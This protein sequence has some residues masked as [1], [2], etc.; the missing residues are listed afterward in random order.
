[1]FA[2]STRSACL[3]AMAVA[4]LHLAAAPA[5]GQYN[6]GGP[7]GPPG[8]PGGYGYGGYYPPGYGWGPGGYLAGGAAILDAT[9]NLGTS[10]EQAR[11]LRE[12]ANQAKLDTKKKAVDVMA[13][14]RTN[15]YWYS[16]E[17]IDINAKVIQAALNNPPTIE[18]TS[19]RALNTLL[20]YLDQMMSAGVPG[21]SVPVDPEVVRSLTVTSGADNGNVGLLKDVDNLEWPTSLVGQTQ[22]DLDTMLKEATYA[23]AMKGKV[24]PAA[25][26]KLNRTTDMLEQEVKTKFHKSEI[27]GGEYLEG[28]RYI[29][30]VRDAINAL[31][32]PTAGKFLSGAF[33]PR[34]DTVDQVVYSMASKGLTFARAQ[35]GQE[36]AYIALHRSFVNFAAAAGIP[37]T[38]F[39]VMVKGSQTPVWQKSN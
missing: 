14:E 15:K 21:P 33:G 13:Y 10:Q 28:T 25:I 27:D 35:P 18:I 9:A 11:I 19:G 32:L 26:S 37:D 38:G 30:R 4:L 3:W 20:P 24:V 6:Y 23:A 22:M 36:F 34:G 39:R 5:A 31:K 7:P 17:K 8:P 29:T 12:Q 16:D 1:M 2:R